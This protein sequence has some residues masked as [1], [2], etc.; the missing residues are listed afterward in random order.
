MKI[1]GHWVD[2]TANLDKQLSE[3]SQ[4]ERYWYYGA[5]K[6]SYSF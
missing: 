5:I 3:L 4:F 2:G 1:E 6:A